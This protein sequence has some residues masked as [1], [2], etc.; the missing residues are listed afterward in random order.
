MLLRQ[1]HAGARLLLV[2]DNAIN[3][4]VA[5]E[6]LNG[7]GLSVDTA[8]TGREAIDKV[9]HNN[10]QLV[11]MDVQM[12]EMDGLEATKIIRAL[13][14]FEQL[15]ILAMTANAFDQ[16]QNSCLTVGMNDFVAKPFRPETLYAKVLHWLSHPAQT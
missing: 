12:P 13:Y 10:Y 15:P 6:L 3:R 9:R 11:L 8:E 14:N 16:D 1:H 5:M 7:V 2:E 4:D